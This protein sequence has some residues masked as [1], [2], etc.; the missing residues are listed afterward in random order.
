MEN[1]DFSRKG[2]K[3]PDEFI[4]KPVLID[5]GPDW[6]KYHLPTHPLHYYDVLRYH[7]NTSVTIETGNDCHVLSI[8]EGGPVAVDTGKGPVMQ[9][10]YAET[11]VVPAAAGNYKVENLSGKE[12]LLVIAFIK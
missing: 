11:F 2:E 8:V 9:F 1:L 5:E 3:V 4:S 12:A 10:S 6:K 7:F